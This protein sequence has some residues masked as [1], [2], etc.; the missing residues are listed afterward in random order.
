MSYIVKASKFIQLSTEERKALVSSGKFIPINDKF[1][2]YFGNR[3]S[4]VFLYGSYGNGKSK[5]ACQDL[6]EKCRTDKYFKCFYGRKIFDRVRSTIFDELATEI[7]ERGLT[8]E[9]SYSRSDNSTMII[10]HKATGNKFTPF[11]GDKPDSLKGIKDPSHIL[12][13]ELD[14]FKETDFG[15][16]FSRLRKEDVKTQFYGLFNTEPLIDTHW[17]RKMLETDIMPITKIFGVY[18]ENYFLN[19]EDYEQKLR[20]IA[21]GREHIF[22]A[23]ANGQFGVMLSENPFFYAY[24]NEKHYTENEYNYNQSL[25]LDISFDFNISPCTALLGQHNHKL[26]TYS[27]FDLILTDNNTMQGES[28]LKALCYTIKRKY[29][30]TGLVVPYRIRV[31]GDASGRQGSADSEVSKTFYYTIR[32]ILKIPEQNFYVR[33]S[34][35]QHTTSAEVCNSVLYNL[36][37]PFFRIYNLPEL[38]TDIGMAFFDAKGTLDE[39]K[40]KHGLHIV[41]AFRYLIDFWFAC[42][43]GRFYKR[44]EDINKNIMRINKRIKKATLVKV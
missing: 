20:L 1:L 26:N 5:F 22:Q 39:A 44:F 8:N 4:V 18:R 29:I 2:P 27:I 33:K 35:L 32:Q 11:G 40:K 3:D 30:D 13:D 23:I 42:D 37:Y 31:T 7:E 28:S 38:R 21:N 43:N 17:L 16:L 25:Y 34:N 9:F 10:T 24:K 36:E 14:Q 41:D 19:V 6:V 12:C 15:F